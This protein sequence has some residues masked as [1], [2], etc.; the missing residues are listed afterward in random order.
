MSFTY[1]L[2]LNADLAVKPTLVPFGGNAPAMTALLG[3]QVDY[4]MGTILD[5]ASQ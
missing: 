2:V 3:S 4:F 5:I 1:A